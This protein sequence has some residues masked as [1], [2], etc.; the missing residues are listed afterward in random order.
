MAGLPL[1][2]DNH[3]RQSIVAALL[4]RSWLVVRAIDVFPEGTDDETL[5]SHAANNDLVFVTS[6]Q[7]IH[8]LAHAW[9]E[10]GRAFRMVF[11]RFSH[12]QRLSDGDVVRQLEAIAGNPVAFGYPIEYVKP[13]P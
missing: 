7:R 9:L 12:H 13:G 8:R 5:F 1:F 4:G 6:D 10:Q 11:W 2:T 3:V